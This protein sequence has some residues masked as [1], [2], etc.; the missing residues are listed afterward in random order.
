[1]RRDKNAKRKIIF[2]LDASREAS[3]GRGDF[4]WVPRDE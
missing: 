4:C 2:C 1:V 3:E